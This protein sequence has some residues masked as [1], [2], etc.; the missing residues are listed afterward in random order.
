MGNNHPEAGDRV[1]PGHAGSR[2]PGIAMPGL[3]ELKVAFGLLY[4]AEHGS[5]S[6]WWGPEDAALLRSRLALVA[7]LLDIVPRSEAHRL[8]S[9]IEAWIRRFPKGQAVS[10]A[11]LRAEA[12]AV[13]KQMVRSGGGQDGLLVSFQARHTTSS[14]EAVSSRD[15]DAERGCDEVLRV[16]KDRLQ[17]D[18]RWTFLPSVVPGESPIHIDQVFVELFAIADDG[19][20][21]SAERGVEG[22]R[23]QS[24]RMLANQYPVVSIPAMVARTLERC[25]VLGEPGS[26]KSTLIQW[27]ARAVANSQC[28]DFDVAVVVKLSA[29]AEALAKDSRLSLIEF[30][31]DSQGA[32]AKN[33]RPAADWL[34]KRAKETHRCLLLLDGWDEVPVGG[35]DAVRN[36]IQQEQQYFVTVI[37]SRP[38]GSPYQLRGTAR[39]DVYRIAGLA[40]QAMRKLIENLLSAIGRSD[41]ASAILGRVHDAADLQEMATNPFLLGLLV[42]IL[43]RIEVQGSAPRTLADIYDQIASVSYAYSNSSWVPRKLADI[44]GQIAAWMQGTVCS[45][46]GQW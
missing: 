10:S 45:G 15:N 39:T 12:M 3:E 43:V 8:D 25:V 6:D 27:L 33:W 7:V 26:G 37:T 5:W 13:L 16:W 18:P 34:R 36:Q 41:L 28:H 9:V 44:Y 38:S 29:Y 22:S 14:G 23:R 24:H 21:D 4:A 19:T 17:N 20:G 40:P 46:G 30:F 42:R 2:E 11:D 31:F 35:R 1:M 32:D